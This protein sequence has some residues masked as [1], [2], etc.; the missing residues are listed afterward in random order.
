MNKEAYG[1][2]HDWARWLRGLGMEVKVL[3]AAL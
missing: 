2:A 1:S 3:P